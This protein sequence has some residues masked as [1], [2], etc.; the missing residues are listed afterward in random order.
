MSY[1]IVEHRLCHTGT[2]ADTRYL[3]HGN[4]TPGVTIAPRFIVVHYTVIDYA[5]TLHAFG[6]DG[7]KQAS[8]HL[9]ISRKGEVTQMVDFNLRA[10]HAGVS[11]WQGLRDL[12]SH[13]IGIELENCGFLTRQTDGRFLSD[14]GVK[15]E[16]ADVLEARH[17]LPQW[18]ARYWERYTPVQIA[19]CENI[20]KALVA[21]YGIRDILGHDDI[22]PQRKADPGPAFPMAQVRMACGLPR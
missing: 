22:A 19:A 11:E 17:K 8:A 14:T 7:S 9:V 13:S 15:L 12:N 20:C 4:H 5:Q 10:W 6:P 2:H 21:A 1:T 18:S 3:G 16:A